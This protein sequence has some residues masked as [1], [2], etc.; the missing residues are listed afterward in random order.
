MAKWIIGRF[1][2]SISADVILQVLFHV[3]KDVHIAPVEA[4]TFAV[5]QK[6]K[7]RAKVN[8]GISLAKKLLETYV[9]S[10]QTCNFRSLSS[11][12]FNQYVHS[13]PLP[14]KLTLPVQKENDEV[15][16]ETVS[17]NAKK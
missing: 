2:V 13:K 17:E 12:P 6:N 5:H 4:M 3:L 14:F 11:R 9:R 15:A 16:G 7:K 1:N 8:L 10:S